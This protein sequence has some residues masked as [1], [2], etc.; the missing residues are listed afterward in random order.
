MCSGFGFC[1]CGHG[2]P[3]TSY[4]FPGLRA[5]SS[6]ISSVK[7]EIGL[8]SVKGPWGNCGLG[9]NSTKRLQPRSYL[10]LDCHFLHLQM[11]WIILLKLMYVYLRASKPC[12]DVI[13]VPHSAPSPSPTPIYTLIPRQ[14]FPRA[15][16][17]QIHDYQ[18]INLVRNH[19]LSLDI[20]PSLGASDSPW[21]CQTP[22][23][24]HRAGW[25]SLDQRVQ[26][27]SKRFLAEVWMYDGGNNSFC[28]LCS[29]SVRQSTDP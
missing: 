19:I 7:D 10:K 5:V 21:Q 8:G 29:P 23:T 28:I 25:T 20:T 15:S 18:S 1:S 27:S 11:A 9:F 6:S 3:L 13:Y 12:S 26:W 17:Y 24:V 4:L 2:L 16:V 14:R 22:L